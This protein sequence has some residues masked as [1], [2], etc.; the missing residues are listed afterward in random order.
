[1]IVLSVESSCDETSVSLIRDGKEILS[2]VVLSQI[3]IHKEYGGV[4]PEIASREHIKGITYVFEEAISKADIEVKDINLVAVTKGPGLIGSLLI[5]VNAAKA[6]AYLNN[7]DI[8]GVHHI[9]GHI[10][11]NQIS[12][13]LVFP[14]VCLVVSGGHTELILMKEH[15]DFNKLG[16]TSDDAVGEAY[17]KVARTIGLGYPGGPI[18]DKL[19]FLGKANYKMPDLKNIPG[20]GFSFSGIKSHVINLVHN[21]EQRK[22]E[23]NKEDLCAS[24]QNAVTDVLVYKS[25]KAIKEYGAKMF[26]IAG[27][28]AANKGLRAKIKDEITDVKIVVPEFKYCTDNAAMI[29]V[30]GYYQY[31]KYKQKDDMKLNGSSRL[32]LE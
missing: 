25:K 28:V 27:G 1:M 23:I 30:A 16:E 6:F 19:A 10:Y 14:L 29:G 32:N 7:I 13:D 5:G 26:M 18:V 2:N 12:E 11:A 21:A 20:Y 17:D 9:A 24:F 15:Y 8:I 31:L 22:E 3:D 4:V